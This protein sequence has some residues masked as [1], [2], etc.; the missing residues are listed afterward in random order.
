MKKIPSKALAILRKR[1]V[2]SERILITT[3][4]NPDGDAIGSSLALSRVL[5][6]MNKEVVVFTPNKFPDFFLWME[7]A[8]EIL[9]FHA[10]EL[11]IKDFIIN[12]DLLICLDFNDSRRL[13]NAEKAV[14]NSSAFKVLIDHH[15][16]PGNFTDIL[17][18][19]PDLGSTAELLYYILNDLKLEKYMD[20]PVAEALYTGIMTDT[21]NFSF[22]S[23]YPEVWN[24]VGN[25][26]ARGINK[27]LIYSR[28]YDTYTE[29]RMR[30]MGY[31]LYEK[32]KIFPELKLGAIGITLEEQ[33]KFG[34][35]PGD[36]EG[37]VN[38]PFSVQGVEIT[39]LFTEKADHVRLSLRS[40]GDFSVNELARK[41]FNGGGHV[42]AAGGELKMTVDEAIN[43]L[44]SRLKE[45]KENAL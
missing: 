43:T 24:V 37:F 17:I 14:L 3:H 32:M 19:D 8:E 5:R 27:D 1:I 9:T 39:A 33:K 2:N 29:Q 31:C 16:Q 42:N 4:I 30:F 36:T 41:Y 20:L 28:V 23:S 45:L 22:A 6:N 11:R 34:H 13:G 44:Y 38:L 10:D 7:G 25:L 15:P 12:T 35:K 21:G 40:R 18:S 26:I